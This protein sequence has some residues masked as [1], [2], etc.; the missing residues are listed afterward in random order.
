VF[1]AIA[2]I[3]DEERSGNGSEVRRAFATLMQ[4]FPQLRIKAAE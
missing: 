4:E 2:A 3:P 1:D